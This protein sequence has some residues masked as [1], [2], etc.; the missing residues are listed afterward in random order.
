LFVIVKPNCAE[1]VTVSPKLTESKDELRIILVGVNSERTFS[2][3][4]CET[5]AEY[6]ESP[7]YEATMEWTPA[8][9]K[10]GTTSIPAPGAAEVAEPSVTEPRGTTEFEPEHEAV[11]LS[12][13]VPEGASVW[14]Q[15][16]PAE[17]VT[18]CPRTTGF[19]VEITLTTLATWA[20]TGRAKRASVST[21][22]DTAA[23]PDFLGSDDFMFVSSSRPDVFQLN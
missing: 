11:S 18:F 15:F 9:G 16:T 1:N 13:I 14:V 21:G 4:G 2:N 10:D 6:V 12:V 20:H 17:M 23:T 7:L 8:H 3:S 19:G 5:P 22:S